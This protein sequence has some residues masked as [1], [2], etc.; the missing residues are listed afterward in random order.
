MELR[1]LLAFN[2][3]NPIGMGQRVMHSL[4]PIAS[5]IGSRVKEFAAD[6]IGDIKNT[7]QKTAKKQEDFETLRQ[8]AYANPKNPLE[9]TDPAAHQE[10]MQVLL[11]NASNFAPAGIMKK[12]GGQFINRVRT[13]GI[14]IKHVDPNLQRVDMT[15]AELRNREEFPVF[16]PEPMTLPKWGQSEQT[17]KA[18]GVLENWINTTQSKW[19][20][21]DAGTADDPV[22]KAINEGAVI[23]NMLSP[24]DTRKNATVAR[25]VREKANAIYLPEDQIPIKPISKTVAGRQWENAI[26]RHLYTST[27]GIDTQVAEKFRKADYVPEWMRKV[28]PNTPIYSWYGPSNPIESINESLMKDLL[29][30]RLRP[31]SMSKVSM[32]DALKSHVARV[33][34]NI[35]A[36]ED[37]AAR[38]EALA[39]PH[40]AYAPGQ[41]NAPDA[42]APETYRWHEIKETPDM[43]PGELEASL[44]REGRLM[45]HCVGDSCP[46]VRKGNVKVFSLRDSQNQPHVTVEVRPN[47]G[48]PGTKPVIS[49]IKGNQNVVKLKPHYEQMVQDFIG[50]RNQWSGI[51][52]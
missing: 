36:E 38:V 23:P 11:D 2:P 18:A 8:R 50:D 14:D 13:P 32:V 45:N 19:L 34:R 29:E 9:I 22:L 5:V 16:P 33:H 26:D 51:D 10:F 1:D 20:K 15:P 12:T 31:E 25:L 46:A 4:D 30:G 41:F 39:P 49:Q 21:R 40:K 43:K 42:T 37:T 44:R 27:A 3:M 28:D 24:A 35:K 52:R 48:K 17:Q 47:A 7:L 6:P